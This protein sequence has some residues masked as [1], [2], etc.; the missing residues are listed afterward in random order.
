M[1]NRLDFFTQG[2]HRLV[3]GSVTEKVTKDR[4]NNNAPIPEDKQ[5]Y[6]FGVAMRKDDPDTTNLINQIHNFLAAEWANDQGKI[7]ALNAYWSNGCQGISLKI[8][9]GD[10]PNAEGK[11]NENTQG[12]FVFY[13]SNWGGQL[14]RTVDPANQDIPGSAVK[15]GYYVQIAGSVK[16]NGE[17]YSTNPRHN[18]CGAYLDSTVIRLVAEGDI[19]T[20]G[21]DAD[22]AF[23]GTTATGVALP[24]GARPLG[25][26]T[27]PNAPG[28][29]I[30][31]GN[32]LPGVASAATQTPQY[33]QGGAPQQTAYPSNPAQNIQ[34]HGQILG[35]PNGGG[36]T[37]LPGLPGT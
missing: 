25:T 35:G 5:R 7:A 14:P 15:R 9:D 34:P 2:V 1:G 36:A 20:G 27:T 21:I 11:L 33:N 37:N 29:T 28:T 4:N 30:P 22:T 12:C 17:A 16:D 18:R 23:G 19:I 3:S 8:K 31:Q 6:E 10:I 32:A 24:V 13:F 26:G